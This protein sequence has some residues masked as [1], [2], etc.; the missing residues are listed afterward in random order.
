M[1]DLS[2]IKLNGTEYNI[3]DADARA[4]ITA[5]GEGAVSNLPLATTASNG[6]MSSND[7]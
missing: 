3:K 5:I 4:A 1:A 2:K 6:L 7:K